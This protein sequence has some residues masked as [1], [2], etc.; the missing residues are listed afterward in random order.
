MRIQTSKPISFCTAQP[1]TIIMKSGQ[2]S[3]QVINA[4]TREPMKEFQCPEGKLYVEAEPDVSTCTVMFISDL[5]F[6][7]TM[8]LTFAS[9]PQYPLLSSSTSSAS[10][11]IVLSAVSSRVS[12]TGAVQRLQLN[13]TFHNLKFARLTN[14]LPLFLL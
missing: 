2:F 12:A 5:L 10:R 9:T 11:P 8:T 14:P 1:V 4:E 6:C 3:L 13:F 7:Q